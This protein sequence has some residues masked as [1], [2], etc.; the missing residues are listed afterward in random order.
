MWEREG[1]LQSYRFGFGTCGLSVS[2]VISIV[3]KLMYNLKT[4]R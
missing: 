2:G 4:T 3:I 1:K